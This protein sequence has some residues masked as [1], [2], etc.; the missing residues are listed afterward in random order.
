MISGPDPMVVTD[1][2]Q[3][4]YPHGKRLVPFFNQDFKKNG[5]NHFYLFIFY[6]KAAKVATIEDRPIKIWKKG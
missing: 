6:K 1:R 5:V 4:N 2:L 3:Q